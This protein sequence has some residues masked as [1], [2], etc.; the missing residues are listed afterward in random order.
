MHARADLDFG[1]LVLS[2]TISPLSASTTCVVEGERLVVAIAFGH[3]RSVQRK[4]LLAGAHHV[5]VEDVGHRFSVLHRDK[6][7][8][9]RTVRKDFTLFAHDNN[10]RSTRRRHSVCRRGTLC[11]RA[12]SL[13]LTRTVTRDTHFGPAMPSQACVMEARLAA[14]LG[15]PPTHRVHAGRDSVSSCSAAASSDMETLLLFLVSTLDAA[16]RGDAWA[17]MHHSGSS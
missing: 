3:V 16:C 9:L 12:T 6:R 1:R 17:V 10:V 2:V 5:R 4:S 7:P 8:G 14:E 13:G 11:V 15:I